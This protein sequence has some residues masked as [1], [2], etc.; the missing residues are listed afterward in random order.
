MEDIGRLKTSSSSCAGF[1]RREPVT[2][3]CSPVAGSKPAGK[4]P[5]PRPHAGAFLA[6]LLPGQDG[7]VNG[8]GARTRGDDGWAQ[9]LAPG[10]GRHGA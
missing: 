7:G 5:R 8:G 6:Y 10:P 4:G 3:T 1:P 9:P 2:G